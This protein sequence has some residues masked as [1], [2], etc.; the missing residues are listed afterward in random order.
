M[1]H[2]LGS[3][4]HIIVGTVTPIKFLSRLLIGWLITPTEF[5]NNPPNRSTFKS[6]IKSS[7]MLHYYFGQNYVSIFFSPHGFPRPDFFFFCQSII[8][9]KAQGQIWVLHLFLG[10]MSITALFFFFVKFVLQSQ[11][12]WLFFGNFYLHIYTL[13]AIY[14]FLRNY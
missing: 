3:E 1:G 10:P 2:F 6:R 5:S 4:T 7:D 12:Q 13:L 8:N 9:R 11:L 14:T